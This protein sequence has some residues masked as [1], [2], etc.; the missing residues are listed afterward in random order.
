ML[1]CFRSKDWFVE[2]EFGGRM[3][4][5][6]KFI[7]ANFGFSLVANKTILYLARHQLYH[8]RNG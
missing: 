8:P 7:E 1:L 6:Y 2:P 5:E 4:P 3:A